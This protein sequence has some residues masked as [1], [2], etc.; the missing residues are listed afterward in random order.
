MPECPNEY[1]FFTSDK[2]EF[3]ADPIKKNDRADMFSF[4]GEKPAN[5]NLQ[6]FR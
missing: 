1:R 4:A 5:E 2:V 3:A 6:A